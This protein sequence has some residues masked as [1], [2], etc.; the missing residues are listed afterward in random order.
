M[1]LEEQYIKNTENAIR[2]LRLGTKSREEAMRIA[3]FNLSRLKN[4]N[5]GLYEDLLKQYKKVI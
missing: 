1:S 3:G 5:I 4:V 2:A